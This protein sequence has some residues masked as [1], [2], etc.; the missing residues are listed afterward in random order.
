MNRR[1]RTWVQPFGRQRDCSTKLKKREGGSQGREGNPNEFDRWK[2]AFS[3]KRRGK[4]AKT[5]TGKN[6]GPEV[7]ESGRGKRRKADAERKKKK[8][9]KKGKGPKRINVRNL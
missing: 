4:N 5:D 8:F 7:R 6:T 3:S 1:R 2:E 9:T